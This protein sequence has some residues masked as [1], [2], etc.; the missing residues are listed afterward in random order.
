MSLLVVDTFTEMFTKV[1]PLPVYLATGMAIGPRGLA[2][3]A[4]D[5]AVFVVDP[6]TG[7]LQAEIPISLSP[8]AIAIVPGG[9]LAYVTDTSVGL[10]PGREYTEPGRISVIDTSQ[11]ILLGTIQAGVRSSGVA[12]TPD[13]SGDANCTGEVNAADLPELVRLISD[14]DRSPCRRDDA[15]H[16]CRLDAD[17][18]ATTIAAMFERRLL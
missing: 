14:G 4:S 12:T 3:L 7:G 1:V 17:D 11:N 8:G 10:L 5:W 2:Y 16:D 13:L 18:I 15:T 9:T 6:A